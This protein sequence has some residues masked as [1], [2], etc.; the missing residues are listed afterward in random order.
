MSW[1]Y[2]GSYIAGLVL[3]FI[4]CFFAPQVFGMSTE[5]FGPLK[6]FIWSGGLIGI[7]WFGHEMHY[8]NKKDSTA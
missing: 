5:N 2:R 1:L 8:A 7:V 4:L 6:K 3:L